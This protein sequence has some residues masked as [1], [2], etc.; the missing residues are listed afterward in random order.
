LLAQLVIAY[1]VQWK[2]KKQLCGQKSHPIIETGVLK[3][4]QNDLQVGL[5]VMVSL[6]VYSND[7]PVAGTIRFANAESISAI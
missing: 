5:S 2:L 7:Q 4:K 3:N 6:A 1:P